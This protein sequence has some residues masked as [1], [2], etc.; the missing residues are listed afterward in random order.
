MNTVKLNDN[1]SW[2]SKSIFILT[3]I[4]PLVACNMLENATGLV[5][6][7]QQVVNNDS[8][9][10]NDD[11]QSEASVSA[12]LS[13]TAPVARED[14]SAISMA[15]IAGFRIYY[16]IAQGGY[17]QYIEVNDV[18]LD[19]YALVDMNL[20]SGTYYIAMTT[21]DTDGRES[22]FSDEVVFSVQVLS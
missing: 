19:E 4:A 5:G 2:I 11:N 1:A 3:M 12:T 7:N 21:I 13:W 10:N 14:G 9:N 18:Y 8:A 17:Q 6:N 15:E 20:T 16:G 22:A